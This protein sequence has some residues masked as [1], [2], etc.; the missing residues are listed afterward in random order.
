M[1]RLPYKVIIIKTLDPYWGY[2]VVKASNYSSMRLSPQVAR[3]KG[4]Q[5]RN[6]PQVK[7][8]GRT[9]ALSIKEKTFLVECLTANSSIKTDGRFVRDGGLPLK[10]YAVLFSGRSQ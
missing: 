10:I 1:Q 3:H 8:S 2:S 9:V 4:S 5:R 6:A 7:R